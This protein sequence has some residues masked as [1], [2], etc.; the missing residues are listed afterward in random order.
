MIEYRN[1]PIEPTITMAINIPD[2]AIPIGNI[3]KATI[4]EAALHRGDLMTL[5]WLLLVLM[6]EMSV[7]LT[8]LF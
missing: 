3:R 6:N 2:K 1:H 8:V 7:V 5:I 4:T